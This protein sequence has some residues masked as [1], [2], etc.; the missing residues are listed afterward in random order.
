VETVGVIGIWLLIF[1][2]G[3]L[4]LKAGE[5]VQA[6]RHQPRTSASAEPSGAWESPGITFRC[7]ICS[8]EA[9]YFGVAEPGHE[10][11]LSS[12]V[13]TIVRWGPEG[14]I[15]QVQ[16]HGR[17]GARARSAMAARDPARALYDIHPPWVT[18]FC[19]GCEVSY[20]S[21]H[22]LIHGGGADVHGRKDCRCPEGHTRE[23]PCD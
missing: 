9:G 20:C 21:K 18:A 1:L 19:P 16:T 11:S 22:W 13:P 8:E 10:Q 5:L 14:G 6:W 17:S 3:A 23:I 4:L 2:I 15:E 7:H 12:S